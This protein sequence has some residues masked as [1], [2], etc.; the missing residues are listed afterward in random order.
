MPV[1]AVEAAAQILLGEVPADLALA[2][3]VAVNYKQEQMVQM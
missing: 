3:Q 1:V 2:E